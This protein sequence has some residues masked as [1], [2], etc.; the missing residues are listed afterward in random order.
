MANKL[1]R[2]RYWKRFEKKRSREVGKV[3]L[4]VLFFIILASSVALHLAEKGIK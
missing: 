2:A 1:R 3:A 4:A